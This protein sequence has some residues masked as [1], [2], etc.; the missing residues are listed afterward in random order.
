[1][2][3]DAAGQSN[4][5]ELKHLF[6]ARRSSAADHSRLFTIQHTEPVTEPSTGLLLHAGLSQFIVCYFRP[7]HIWLLASYLINSW[8]FCHT[9]RICNLINS[10]ISWVRW[11]SW[12]RPI[13]PFEN[14]TLTKLISRLYIFLDF[15]ILIS[16]SVI[17]ERYNVVSVREIWFNKLTHPKDQRINSVAYSMGVAKCSW[18]Y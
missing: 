5:V 6:V 2:C 17:F 1:M 13:V 7:N 3:T 10:L 15:V 8:A 12:I 4:H 9:R 14:T 16:W 18:I 11:F